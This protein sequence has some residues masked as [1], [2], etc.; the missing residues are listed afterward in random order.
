M[1]AFMTVGDEIILNENTFLV[2]ETDE[3]GIIISANNDFC[4][5][6]GYDLEELIGKPHSIIRH[7]DMPK[8]ILSDLKNSTKHGDLWKGIIKNKTK[9]SSKFYWTFSIIVPIKDKYQ[10]RFLCLGVKPTKEEV[11]ECIS[12]F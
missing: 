2:S 6:S 7:P 10:K 3:D 5:I 8:E 1:E 11:K 12:T 4:E 9:D